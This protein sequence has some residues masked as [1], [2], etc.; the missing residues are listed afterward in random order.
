MDNDFIKNIFRKFSQE[1]KAVTRKFGGTGL[2]MTITKELIQLMNGRITIES[3]KNVGTT[4]SVYISF[5]KGN[6]ENLKNTFAEKP[7]PHIDN[8]SILLV[9]DNVLNRMVAQNSLAY[10]NCT[11]TEAE[12]GLI[13]IAILKKQKFD[14]ILMDIQMP[15]MDGIEATKIIRNELQID[16]PIIALTASAFKTEI[17]KCKDAGM[18]DYIAKPFKESIMI[19]TIAKFT[20]DKSAT[21][22]SETKQ[23]GIDHDKKCYSL[24]YLN[25]LGR[26][27]VGFTTKM[28]TLFVEQ[29]KTTLVK[30][31]QAISTENFEEVARLVHEIKP[32]IEVLGIHSVIEDIKSLEKNAKTT[33]DKTQ[34]TILFE[35]INATL[36]QV[37]VQLQKNELDS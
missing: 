13:A 3:E 1:D 37:I 8:I 11:V 12:N 20:T 28:L 21:T 6:R 9:E 30:T 34:I 7:L 36:Q 32:S 22:V 15:E 4:F 10:Y 33:H 35:R 14:I 27:D 29:A 25:D 23:T 17:E 18:D 26:N 2:G 5:E 24:D 31:E 19:E 16:T